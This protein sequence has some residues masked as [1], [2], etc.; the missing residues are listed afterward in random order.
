MC[1]SPRQGRDLELVVEAPVG[2]RE[3]VGAR[4]R[5][6]HAA[7]GDLGSVDSRHFWLEG[8]E[9]SFLKSPTNPRLCYNQFR[10]ISVRKSK[11]VLKHLLDLF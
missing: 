7:A 11:P 3:P 10:K 9:G 1:N 5:D 2:A 8:E 4:D 6:A